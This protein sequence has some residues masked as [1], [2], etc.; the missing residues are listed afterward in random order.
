MRGCDRRNGNG[1]EVEPHR[2]NDVEWR[3]TDLSELL[4]SITYA[5]L[6]GGSHSSFLNLMSQFGFWPHVNNSQKLLEV[7]D[8][9]LS[10]CM[11]DVSKV[12]Q[13][14]KNHLQ[15]CGSCDTRVLTRVICVPEPKPSVD[16][17]FTTCRR[18]NS[19]RN[20]WKA[21]SKKSNRLE[22]KGY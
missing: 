16:T 19:D 14:V 22:E 18:Y 13:C 21:I 12:V 9:H 5:L 3:R 11:S 15:H 1:D 10:P 6:S 8:S 20:K 17:R 4:R 2:F 7:L